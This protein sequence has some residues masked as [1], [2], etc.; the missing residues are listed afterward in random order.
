MKCKVK[1]VFSFKYARGT[2][3]SIAAAIAQ[4]LSHSSRFYSISIDMH[5]SMKTF[6]KDIWIVA[7]E[8]V[9]CFRL[10]RQNIGI[11]D[12]F[13]QASKRLG[14]YIVKIDEKTSKKHHFLWKPE[15]PDSGTG[16]SKSPNTYFYKTRKKRVQA[17]NHPETEN[18][19]I[20]QKLHRSWYSNKCIFRLN[21]SHDFFA[22]K[23]RFSTLC[24]KNNTDSYISDELSICYRCISL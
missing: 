23:T 19:R 9:H 1:N 14:R 12:D 11:Y 24:I 18:P 2:F 20:S 3:L 8:K 15:I 22:Q 13:M 21:L 7:L 4:L 5:V 16:L 6:L 17:S 10:R